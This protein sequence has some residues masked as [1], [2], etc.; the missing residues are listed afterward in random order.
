MLYRSILTSLLLLTSTL[1]SATPQFSRCLSVVIPRKTQQITKHPNL[2]ISMNDNTSQ[3]SFLLWKRESPLPFSE[4]ILSWNALRPEQGKFLFW[5]NIK[6]Q[7]GW[8]GWKKIAEWGTNNQKTFYRKAHHVHIK[9]VRAEMQ[10]KQVGLAYQIKVESVGNADLRRIRALFANVA[11]WHNFKKQTPDD[12][13]PSTEIANI[14]KQSQWWLDHPRKADLCSPTAIGTIAQYFAKDQKIDIASLADHVHDAA[15][16]IYGNW[17]FN[18]AQSFATT[19]GNV[20]YRVERLNNFA[21]LH[22]YLTKNIPVAVGIRGTLKG[23]AWPYVRGHFVVVICWDQKKRQVICLD[24]AFNKKAEIVR[25]Y[26]IDDFI[27]TWGVS[28]NLAYVPIPN[29]RITAQ[30]R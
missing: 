8:L 29:R 12:S 26:P 6:H 22:R 27:R 10:N 11:N 25:H 4:L 13:L 7:T 3:N 23:C 30:L 5:I 28:R 17:I 21:Q 18:V 15:L 20:L 14:T 19:K 24:S 16:D 1:L 9:H 2:T